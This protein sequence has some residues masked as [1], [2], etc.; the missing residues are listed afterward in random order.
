MKIPAWYY[1][2]FDADFALDVPG[3]GYG[4]WQ[5]QPLEFALEHT[6]LVVMHAWDA[7]T[8]EEFPGWHRCVEYIPRANAICRGVLP[9][10]L[11]A[12]RASGMALFHVAGGGSYYEEYPG[13]RRALALAEPELAPPPHVTADPAYQELVQFRADNVFVGKHNAADVRRG[14]ERLAFPPEAEPQGDEG[15]AATGNQ[16]YALCRERGIN[17][18]IYTG[19]A[20]NWC[21]LLS[22]GGMHDMQRYG[23][24]CSAIREAVTAVENKETARHELCKDLALWRVALAF[25]FVFDLPDILNALRGSM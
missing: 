25:G 2:H 14:F 20:I 16:L 19:F 18:L 7:G 5:R 8:R 10:L 6:A 3:E 13:H 15:I 21:L 9:E 17:H 11:G 24:L 23:F 1:R 22:P 4:G 12:V